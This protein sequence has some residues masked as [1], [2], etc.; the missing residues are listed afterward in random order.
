MSGVRGAYSSPRQR[1]RQERILAAAR[2]L[3]AE[4]GYDGLTMR[5]LARASGVSDKTLYNLFTSKDRLVLSAVADL[6]DAIGQRVAG[7][8]PAAGLATLLQYSDC[9]MQQVLDTPAYA[10]AMATSL[11]QADARSPLVGVLLSSNER[12]L[13][14]ELR[15]ALQRKELVADVDPPVLARLLG[16]H[17]WGVLLMWNKGLLDVHELP[18]ASIRSLCFTL[19]GVANDKG[20]AIINRRL[21][22]LGEPGVHAAAV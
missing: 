19:N 9:M 7:C 16:A 1:A 13:R 15:H 10:Q 17:M 4:K 11:F 18:A 5:D 22:R 6:L 20:E 3:I 21:S 2:G 14:R 8:D 12:F